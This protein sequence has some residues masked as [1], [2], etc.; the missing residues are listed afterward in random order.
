MSDF[1]L[2]LVVGLGGLG[3]GWAYGYPCGYENGK[4]FGH[5]DEDD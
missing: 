2:I 4:D 5:L 3:I 1:I